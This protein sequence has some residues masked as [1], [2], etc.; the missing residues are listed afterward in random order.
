M[1][2]IVSRP[3]QESSAGSCSPSTATSSTWLPSVA[4]VAF[5]LHVARV[6]GDFMFARF[7]GEVLDRGDHVAQLLLHLLQA[8]ADVRGDAT[9]TQQSSE[10]DS[11]G[12]SVYH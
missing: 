5:L 7:D 1:R 10:L 8:L 9:R 2:G 4:S 6:G 12:V 11:A 3:C